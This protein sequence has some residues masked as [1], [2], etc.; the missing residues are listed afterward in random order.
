MKTIRDD[1]NIR[2]EYEMPTPVPLQPAKT[3]AVRLFAPVDSTHR[4]ALKTSSGK[5]ILV[6]F[7]DRDPGKQG[8]CYHPGLDRWVVTREFPPD[9]LAPSAGQ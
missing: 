9:D 3:P 2:N 6:A 5:I 8:A 7:Y 4:L 1:A